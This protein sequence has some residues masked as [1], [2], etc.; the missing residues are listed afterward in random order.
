MKNSIKTVTNGDASPS[1]SGD[2]QSLR[3]ALFRGQETYGLMV[4]DSSGAIIDWSQAAER[5][6]GYSR[7]EVLGKSP[8]MF[9]PPDVAEESTA[10]VL[11]SLEREGY[12]AGEMR[13][14]RKDGSEGV[15][16]TAV[17][18]FID[19]QGRPARIGINRDITASK[20]IQSALRESAERLRLIT[21]NV[22]A[23]IVYLDADQRYRFALEIV[24]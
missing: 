10:D 9:H 5:I 3:H 23:V 16:D 13:V 1:I 8:A 18:S 11:A 15:T 24:V 19:E 22:A 17:F 7:D 6:Y 2:D 4:T 14:V 21:D 12:W 20:H